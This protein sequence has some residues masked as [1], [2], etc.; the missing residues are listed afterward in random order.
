MNRD[1]TPKEI[2]AGFACAAA[3]LFAGFYF[4]MRFG[5]EEIG[6]QDIGTMFWRGFGLIAGAIILKYTFALGRLRGFA[7][8]RADGTIDLDNFIRTL[9]ASALVF[10][11]AVALC[12]PLIAVIRAAAR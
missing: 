8:E 4:S 5:S 12:M 6:R 2:A 11:C 1:I 9:V 3:T 10:F 7:V